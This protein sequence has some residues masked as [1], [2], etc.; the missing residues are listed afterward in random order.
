MKALALR[1]MLSK[2]DDDVEIVFPGH[3][4][5]Y[6]SVTMAGLRR[7]EKDGPH[8]YEPADESS[9]GNAVVLVIE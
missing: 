2:I 4:H 7:V 9:P 6:H 3:D 1:T 5:C 8:F